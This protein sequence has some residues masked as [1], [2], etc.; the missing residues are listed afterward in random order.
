VF[1][2]NLRGYNYVVIKKDNQEIVIDK[3]SDD[4]IR[5]AFNA[6]FFTNLEFSSNGNYLIYS[7]L[8]W[9]W[10]MIRI[11]DIKN[12]KIIINLPSIFSY[13]FTDN[14]EQFFACAH[15]MFAG[16]S[17][18]K[19]FTLPEFEETFSDKDMDLF[20]EDN[21]F[22]NL[23]CELSNKNKQLTIT[24]SEFDTYLNK[25]N[26]NREIIYI[27]DFETNSFNKEEKT[28]IT[29]IESLKNNF[30]IYKND[31]L[32]IEITYPEG[33]DIKSLGYRGELEYKNEE[34]FKMQKV[35]TERETDG[36]TSLIFSITNNINNLSFNDVLKNTSYDY[37]GEKYLSINNQSFYNAQI[38]GWG[39]VGAQQF[40]GIVNNRVYNIIVE[41]VDF[42]HSEIDEI[43]HSITFLK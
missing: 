26:A 9:E 7:A 8:G 1:T 31:I 43:I 42:N 23:Q 18:L 28:D 4:P 36:M 30:K 37:V 25:N 14:E 6:L 3:A 33:W 24:A 29:Q 15:S 12:N 10:H 2:K 17:Y 13:G 32:G 35:I 20:D 38:V 21:F 27:Y 16:T 34:G 39:M 19:I 5:D 41:G 22:Y 40:L 11:Y